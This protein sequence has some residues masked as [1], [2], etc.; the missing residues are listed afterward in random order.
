V[1]DLVRDL[2]DSPLYATF[3]HMATPAAVLLQHTRLGVDSDGMRRLAV[4]AL[5]AALLL[6]AVTVTAAALRGES[7]DLRLERRLEALV[8]AGM[9]GALVR[10][11]DG[12]GV[13][14]LAR[15][16][17]RPG[18]RFR[19]GSVT[20]T[21]VAALTLELADRGVLALDDTV[22]AHL[23]GLLRDGN[24]VTIRDLLAH[25]AGLFDYTSDPAL[26]RD[27][28]SPRALVA[29]ADRRERSWGYAYSSTNYLALGLVLEEATGEPLAELLRRYVLEPFGLQQ[30]A[31]EPGLV[32]G[33]HLH[34]HAL[35]ARDGVASGAPRD[36]SRITAAS[37]WAAAAIVSTAADLDRFFSRLVESGLA[38]RMAPEEGGRYGLGLGR[39]RTLCGDALGHT[40]NILGTVTVVRV[41]GDR[42][43]VVAGNAYPFTPEVAERFDDLVHAATCG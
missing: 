22:A 4:G 1:V 7:D 12:D 21:Y 9:P 26:L 24:R 39:P 23:P 33:R 36:T 5:A 28:L 20:K 6:A 13:L 35:A 25:T 43:V 29:I 18:I 2:H 42:L 30:T 38:R 32:P 3:S 11:R 37:A 16:E 34:G 40:G 27:D 31:F 17:A 15:G 10:V 14:E 19:A 41:R 8:A